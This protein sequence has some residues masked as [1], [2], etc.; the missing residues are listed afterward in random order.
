M[1]LSLLLF[2]CLAYDMQF[3][4]LSLQRCENRF[5]PCSDNNMSLIEEWLLM[6]VLVAFTWMHEVVL[7]N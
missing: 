6:L 7:N 4:L 1:K 5:L 3:E 2:D